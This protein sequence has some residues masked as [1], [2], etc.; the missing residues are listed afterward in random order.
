MLRR[1]GNV[2]GNPIAT[3]D[4]SATGVFRISATQQKRFLQSFLRTLKHLK[5]L[6]LFLR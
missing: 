4:S 6:C 1:D 2:I 5:N 3:N